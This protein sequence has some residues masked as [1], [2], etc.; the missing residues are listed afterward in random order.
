MN[1][2]DTLTIDNN[3]YLKWLDS[4][5]TSR[6]NV[7][8][9]DTD[10]NVNFKSVF[11]KDLYINNNSSSNTFLNTSNT[12]NV[13]VSSKLAVGINNTS[14]INANLTLASNTFI[15]I[16]TTQGSNDGF[17]AL[18]GSSVL[19]NNNSSRIVLQGINHS[20]NGKIK[21][22]SANHTSASINF[23]N[24]NDSL[25]LQIKNDGS[26]FTPDGSTIRASITNDETIIT[27]KLYLT[28]TTESINS[29][30]GAVI[31]SGGIG[32]L[33]NCY[34]DGTLSINDVSGNINFDS[35][36]SSTSYTT[37]AIFISGGLGISNTTLASS[38]T[39]GGAISIAGGMAVGENS[40]FGGVMTIDNTT[41][42]INSLSGCLILQ[43][44]LGLN[45]TVYS[46][47]N[48]NNIKL[49]PLTNNAES[50]ILFYSTN[51]FSNTSTGGSSTWS[52][53]QGIGTI[54]S[55][56]FGLYSINSGTIFT[57]TYTGYIGI[58][59]TN[60][61]CSLD[62]NGTLFSN[63][64]T[65]TNLV[66]TFNT[67]ANIFITNN[68]TTNLFTTFNT[69]S[70]VLITNNTSTNL[71]SDFSTISNVL[72]T[73]NTTTNFINTYS[74]LSNVLLTNNT[75]TNFI[76]TYS[77]LANVLLTNNTTTNFINTY[78]TLA[79][80][81]LTNNT[82][83]NFINTYSTLANVLTINNSVSNLNVINITNG[84][85]YSTNIIST[86]LTASNINIPSLNTDN[87]ITTNLTTTNL[88]NTYSTLANI[89]VTHSSVS[90]LNVINITNGTLYS[91]NI[92]STNLTASNI[93]IPSLNT[94]NIITT[95]FTTTNLN[96]TYSTIG[97]LTINTTT[98]SVGIG[99]GGSLTV[100]GGASF[101]KDVY[102]G[103]AL[104]SSSDIRL[105]ENILYLGNGNVLD[106]I[107]SIRTIRYNY[108]K[109]IDPNSTPQIG[110]IAQDFEKDYP[111]L[112]KKNGEF[113]SLDYQKITVIL[114]ECIKELK[115]IIIK[116]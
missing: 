61:Q 115:S 112:I 14:N 66:T 75:T 8:V 67:L 56:N 102:V 13:L 105:K 84:T 114:L 65:T 47:T 53:G 38:I 40:F 25:N 7:I 19:D 93:N 43:G 109:D 79:N 51:N 21:I 59:N 94:T 39:S 96:N 50:S 11:G 81:L 10:N 37:G 107:D 27:N 88:N 20:D 101:S 70:N 116:K 98:Q 15:G 6:S 91:T 22:Y 97:S 92:I 106:T 52:I 44:G 63:N 78:S 110:F 68:T 57:A 24:G 108:I 82:T 23:Y 1:F 54:G 62:V 87:V 4:T 55:G 85:L 95:N 77:T 34:I 18:S 80:V 58:S 31:I 111:E 46:R 9:L 60:P 29:S 104:T 113:Y 45:N 73:N 86:N 12:K 30:T 103:G 90:N 76:N 99:S 69:L 42:S 48:N 26:Y 3:K 33:G 64:I 2:K 89:L 74:T 35:S 28:D 32:V 16:N 100:L 72:L 36:T 49:A 5:G 41:E 83:T 17:L 71:L